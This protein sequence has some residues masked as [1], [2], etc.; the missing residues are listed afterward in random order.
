M[1]EI[2]R[3]ELERAGILN[4]FF[5]ISIYNSLDACTFVY[6]TV[7]VYVWIKGKNQQSDSDGNKAQPEKGVRFSWN[8]VITSLFF[9]Y[10]FLTTAS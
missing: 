7:D 4:P 5:S 3:E 1:K 9:R 6:V 8:Q 10:T 2:I